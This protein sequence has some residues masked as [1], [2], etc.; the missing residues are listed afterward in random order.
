MLAGQGYTLNLWYDSDALLAYQTNK[1]M[2]EAAKAD[3]L[4][5]VGDKTVDENALADLYEERAIV[6]KRQMQAHL[7]EAVAKGQSADDA[8]VDLLVRAYGQDA[9]SLLSCASRTVAPC[10]P[11]QE[12]ICSCATLTLRLFPCSFRASMSRKCVC[13]AIW[14]QLRISCGSKCCIARVAAMPMSITCRLWWRS[15]RSR[16]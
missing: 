4:A 11:W 9:A 13:A 8:R 1:L 7:N 6:L 12:A 2:V 5:H 14:R 15:W 3:A 16:S 10:K